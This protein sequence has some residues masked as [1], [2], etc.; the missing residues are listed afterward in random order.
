MDQHIKNRIQKMAKSM[1]NSVKKAKAS[2]VIA[3]VLDKDNVAEVSP[4]E[5]APNKSGVLTKSKGKKKLEKCG[6]DKDCGCGK[7]A[8]FEKGE[9]FVKDLLTKFESISSAYLKKK[10]IKEEEGELEKARIDDGLNAAKKK[11]ARA[12][13]KPGFTPNKRSKTTKDGFREMPKPQDVK[14]KLKEKFGAS[15]SKKDLEYP[16]L[17]ASEK[18]K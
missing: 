14:A 6:D 7:P 10:E 17:A 5:V 15:P 2:S 8:D 18:T 4:D 1:S 16:S 9:K 13:R 12:V 3:D 11:Q